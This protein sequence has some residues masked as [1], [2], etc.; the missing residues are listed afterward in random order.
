MINIDSEDSFKLKSK[1]I[2]IY[3]NQGF[4]LRYLLRS[5]VLKFL[6]STNINVVLIS[7]NA[8]EPS[9]KKQYESDQVSVEPFD[10]IASENFLKKSKLQRILIQIRSFV[11]SGKKGTEGTLT[12]DD[13]R[14]YFLFD[15]GWIKGRKFK[16]FL[17]G[18]LFILITELFKKNRWI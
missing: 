12:L 6:L 3:I 4:T 8:N 16:D 17:F 5:D 2:F 18:K 7:H 13:F 9:F 10:F 1:C 11:L 14:K 15:K